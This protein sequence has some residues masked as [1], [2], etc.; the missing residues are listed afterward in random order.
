MRRARAALAAW[1]GRGSLALRLLISATLWSAVALLAGGLALSALFREAVEG[2][3]DAQL[4]TLVESLVASVAIDDQGRVTPARAL[5]EARFNQVFS[6]WYWQIADVQG[7]VLRSRSLFDEELALPAITAAGALRLVAPGPNEQSLR[8]VARRIFLADADAPYVFAVAADRAEIEGE[9]RAFNGTL[10]GALGLLGL[11]LVAAMVIQVRFGLLPL[12][13]IGQAL[14]AIRAGRADRLE[15]P[16]PRELEPLALELN[17][18]LEHNA[19][20]VER[21]RTHVGN[22]AHALKTPLSVLANEAAPATGPLAETVARQVAAM[23]AQV[24]HHLARARA[25]GSSRVLGARTR[26]APVLQDLARVLLR[27]HAERGLGLSID[28]PPELAFR[29]EREDF[30]EMA[31]NLLDNACKWARTRVAVRVAAAADGRLL[32]TVEDDGPG[33][34]AT[35]RARAIERGTR[36]DESVPGS[37]FGLAIVR[38]IARLYGGAVALGDAALGGL[39]VAVT[40]PA[41]PAN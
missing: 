26:L 4:A 21:A 31:G 38:D 25:L 20:V 13:R 18:L 37:G 1:L 10:A 35:E 15:G 11:G 29:G 24:D 33:I 7:A 16:F 41:A 19:Q 2:R 12:R 28:C 39:A 34:A 8:I 9:V 3:L 40:L 14:A 30:E 36:L 5:G 32:L 6:G 23:R 27:I 17:A 22:L